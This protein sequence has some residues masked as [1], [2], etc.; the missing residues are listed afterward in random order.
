MA[1]SKVEKWTR[2]STAMKVNVPLQHGLKV[3]TGQQTTT[4]RQAAAKSQVGIRYK[5]K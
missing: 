2:V 3:F 4:P 1:H 5:S